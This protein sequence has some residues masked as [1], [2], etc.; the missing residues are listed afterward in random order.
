MTLISLAIVISISSV[1]LV[2]M[3]SDYRS[4]ES[5]ESVVKMQMQRISRWMNTSIDRCDDF[6]GYV[7]GNFPSNNKLPSLSTVYRVSDIVKGWMRSLV[8]NKLSQSDHK[9][10][11]TKYASDFYTECTQEKVN[12]NK[13]RLFMK[14][15]S[16]SYDLET[17][18]AKSVVYMHSSL[19]KLSIKK[20]P[21]DEHNSSHALWID[22]GDAILSPQL[23]ISDE[24][25]V[26]SYR[27]TL[28]LQAINCLTREQ[29]SGIDEAI[30]LEID[31]AHVITNS[32]R[33]R[34]SLERQTV[35]SLSHY[36]TRINWTQVM[37]KVADTVNSSQLSGDTTVI[38]SDASYI[39]S[40][41]AILSRYTDQVITVFILL[42][43][44]SVYGFSLDNHDFSDFEYMSKATLSP[45]SY[46]RTDR[47]V[48]FLIDSVPII[49]GRLFLDEWTERPTQE[50]TDKIIEM[51]TIISN[52]LVNKI[53]RNT[54]LSSEVKSILVKK[55]QS[56]EIQVSQPEWIFNDDLIDQMFPL[57][58]LVSRL[59]I[60]THKV[61][62]RKY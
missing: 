35:S 26:T 53:E 60:C 3:K 58:K 32:T 45:S 25:I 13:L 4:N 51:T 52:V 21:F 10:Q 7:C 29:K 8:V 31:L 54:W 23:L 56:I 43:F 40:L 41:D 39:L 22:K 44:I 2:V 34:I 9:L 50:S 28:R 38:L 12:G 19:I 14:K 15:M 33:D 49:A 37:L 18:L 30:N 20:N 46:N 57:D 36:S 59:T 17:L 11:V 61:K 62:Q 27:E 16:E 6:Y 5:S 1:Y 48:D 24:E 42:R 47:C 55:I